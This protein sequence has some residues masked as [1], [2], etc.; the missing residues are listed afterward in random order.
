VTA[1]A[2]TADMAS[3][4]EAGLNVR[5]TQASQPSRDQSLGKNAMSAFDPERT[6]ERTRGIASTRWET[7]DHV[8]ENYKMVTSRAREVAVS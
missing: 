8:C 3:G 4:S 6:S 1:F 7:F 2:S 5:H